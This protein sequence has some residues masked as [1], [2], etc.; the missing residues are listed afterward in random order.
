[1]GWSEYTLIGGCTGVQPYM[2]MRRV[3]GGINM[4]ER[5][6]MIALVDVIFTNKS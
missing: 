3:M 4:V 1:M 5:E 6:N 2:M